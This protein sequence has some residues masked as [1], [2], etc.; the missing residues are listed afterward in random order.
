MLCI[1]D[2][3]VLFLPDETHMHCTLLSAKRGPCP[4]AV[5]TAERHV[6]KQ[7]CISAAVVAKLRHGNEVEFPAKYCLSNCNDPRSS[8]GGLPAFF[9]ETTKRRVVHFIFQYD[10]LR[11]CFR[12]D[13]IIAACASVELAHA[14]LSIS[15]TTDVDCFRYSLPPLKS[16]RLSIPMLYGC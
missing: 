11:R 14:L 16:C 8:I 9:G 3:K 15:R 4:K 2:V 6:S 10:L 12:S 7:Q 13:K 1:K 5:N